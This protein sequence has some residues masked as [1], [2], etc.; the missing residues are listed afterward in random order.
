VGLLL[1]RWNGTFAEDFVEQRSAFQDTTTSE[2][3]GQWIKM[4]RSLAR[5]SGSEP[6]IQTGF[7]AVFITIAPGVSFSVHTG[8]CEL[9]AH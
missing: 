9:I 2:R 1:V 3:I 5:F 4:R 6:V 7:S 8:C